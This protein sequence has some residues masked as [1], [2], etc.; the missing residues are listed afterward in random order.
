MDNSLWGDYPVHCK[1]F[2]GTPVLYLL[3]ASACLPKFQQSKMSP[4]AATCPRGVKIICS[5]THSPVGGHVSD[6]LVGALMSAFLW[7][8]DPGVALLNASV[9]LCFA[10]I[11]AAEKLP[12][13]CCLLR[14]VEFMNS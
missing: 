14:K 5:L 7:G 13:G 11:D 6:S 9:G 3:E 8:V 12:S 2:S 10:L 4:D 1:M